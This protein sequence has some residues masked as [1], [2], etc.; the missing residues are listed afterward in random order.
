MLE[1]IERDLKEA[2]LARD[3]VR[4]SVLK[5]LKSD[6]QNKAIENKGTLKDDDVV[7]VVQKAIKSRKEA[8]QMY[9][10]SGDEVRASAESEEAK[11]LEEY[12]PEQ[13]SDDEL[14]LIVNDIFMSLQ[15]KNFGELMGE[16]MK[17][18]GAKAEGKRVAQFVKERLNQ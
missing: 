2:M 13:L 7:A 12:L 9:E 3:I 18:V 10:D 5:M 8:A 6:L 11:I 16:V 15:T 4:T 14:R 1:Q 17:Q